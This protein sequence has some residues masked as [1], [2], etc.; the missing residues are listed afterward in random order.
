MQ[1]VGSHP[2]RLNNLYF[3]FLFVLRAVSKAA[4]HLS[5]YSYDT[6]DPFNDEYIATL[7][8]LLVHAKTPSVSTAQRTL[9]NL[10]DEVLRTSLAGVTLEEAANIFGEDALPPLDDIMECR[11]GFDEARLFQASS[12]GDA[13]SYQAA[14]LESKQLQETFRARF[15]NITR[16]MDCVACDKCRVWGK[17]QILGL[18]TSIKILLTSED[19]LARALMVQLEHQKLRDIGS[20]P[21]TPQSAPLLT[22]QEI[23]ALINTLHQLSVSI[24]FAAKASEVELNSVLHSFYHR[25]IDAVRIGLIILLPIVWIFKKVKKLQQQ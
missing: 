14:L 16:I 22:R 20:K 2:E 10:S 1:R 11:G 9:F 25:F 15:R 21:Q 4:S 23:I 3:T 7:I 12:S 8:R 13:S 6:G 5:A 18:G 17:L 19:D 24:L